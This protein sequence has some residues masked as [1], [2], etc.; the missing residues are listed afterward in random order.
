[1]WEIITFLI[2]CSGVAKI[3]WAIARVCKEGK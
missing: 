1:M 3:I 2:I